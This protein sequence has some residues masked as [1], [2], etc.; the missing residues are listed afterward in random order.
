[1]FAPDMLVPT[2]VIMPFPVDVVE[3]VAVERRRFAAKLPDNGGEGWPVL[4]KV[5]EGV[6]VGKTLEEVVR[7]RLC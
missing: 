1:M 5:E 6:T 4:E 7:V 2:R 3:E